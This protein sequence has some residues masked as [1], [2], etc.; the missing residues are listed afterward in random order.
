MNQRQTAIYRKTTQQRAHDP[1]SPKSISLLDLYGTT[2]VPD[3]THS[4]LTRSTR[5]EN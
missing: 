2:Q 5:V 1:S 3:A 4:Y